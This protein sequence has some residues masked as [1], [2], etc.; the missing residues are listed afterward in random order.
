[1]SS[2]IVMMDLHTR[3]DDAIRLGRPKYVT[4]QQN[5]Q[6]EVHNREFVT[7]CI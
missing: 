4:K 1:M 2:N 3:Q 5:D 6:Y 7:S